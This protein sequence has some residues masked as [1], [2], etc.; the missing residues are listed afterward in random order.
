MIICIGW[1]CGLAWGVFTC[2]GWMNDGRMDVDE[3]M[4]DMDISDRV[5]T[6]I[7]EIG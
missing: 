3:R 5:E 1:W 7:M 6:G 2:M 4:R